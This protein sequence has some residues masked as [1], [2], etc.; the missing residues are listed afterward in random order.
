[1]SEAAAVAFNLSRTPSPIWTPVYWSAAFMSVNTANIA[2]L[3]YERQD[4]PL[5]PE[6]EFLYDIT[7]R[8]SGMRKIQFKRLIDAGKVV[9]FDPNHVIFEEGTVNNNVYILISGT[10]VV[11]VRGEYIATVC[12]DDVGAFLGEMQLL[13]SF[14]DHAT[15]HTTLRDTSTNNA[16][17]TSAGNASTG[18]Y[19]TKS[20][21][22]K[23]ASES[24]ES[25][26][27]VKHNTVTVSHDS[28]VVAIEWDSNYL[29]TVLEEQDE[30]A[31]AMRSVLLST[32]LKKLRRTSV[33]QENLN[34]D[35][36]FSNMEKY[37]STG[38]ITELQK[39]EIQKLAIEGS[40]SLRFH[41][42]CLKDLSWTEQEYCA[43]RKFVV[44]VINTEVAAGGSKRVLNVSDVVDKE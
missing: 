36:Y 42:D 12:A 18:H 11:T 17:T 4:I 2:S 3:L 14:M 21:L 39:K 31:T 44:P 41:Y 24:E 1:M 5:S 34:E 29:L 10:V 40:I 30:L 28:P 16:S 25:Q 22:T 20:V 9:T 32:L 27:R 33:Q 19:A 38:H 6:E 26:S 23:K 35:H 37:L 15:I 43:G 8:R 13:E 7:F